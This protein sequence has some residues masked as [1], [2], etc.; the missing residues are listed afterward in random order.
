VLIG[1]R[2][3]PP[4]VRLGTIET[5]GGCRWQVAQLR[6]VRQAIIFVR[7][8]ICAVSVSVSL[9]GLHNA[10]PDAVPKGGGNAKLYCRVE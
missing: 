2:K 10:V 9:Q 1:G 8:E 4:A 3:A 6:G 7:K 5:S